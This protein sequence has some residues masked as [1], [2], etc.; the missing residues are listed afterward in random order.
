MLF[1]IPISSRK[2]D[3]LIDALDLSSSDHV[4]DVGCGRGEF[5]L[6]TCTRTS[7]HGFGI[8][9]D[10]D[11]I[12]AASATAS[13]RGIR[14]NCVFQVADASSASQEPNA[15]DAAVCLGSTHAFGRGDIAYPNAL[16]E[17]TR[18]VKPGG[19]LL[20]GEGYW[21]QNPD[22]DYLDLIGEPVGIYHDHAG[23]VTL[24]EKHRLLPLYALTSNDDEWDHFEWSHRRA[25]EA[26][27]AAAPDNIELQQRV[28]NSRAWRDGY[29]KWGRS[30]MG[31]GFYLFEK[32]LS[33]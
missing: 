13:A 26:K 23:N 10:S 8:D 25:I 4:I 15:F 31:F 24:A 22:P 2:V 20:I 7:C 11:A 17:L 5:L 16:R 21:K 3:Q 1:N 33:P 6:R 12:A 9:Q 27:L 29:L 32:P 18:I 30:T 14:E 28:K 19:L